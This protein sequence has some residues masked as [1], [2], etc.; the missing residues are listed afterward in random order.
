MNKA[1]LRKQAWRI[2]IKPD[3]LVTSTLIF[4]YC[5]NEQFTK[6]EPK[7]G[8]SWIWKNLLTGRDVILKET[9]VQI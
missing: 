7:P 9:D 8:N 1:L 2:I 3:S 5:K 4:K 6:V